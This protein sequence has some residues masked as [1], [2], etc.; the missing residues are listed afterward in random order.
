M[1]GTEKLE[2]LVLPTLFPRG[3]DDIL[4]VFVLDYLEAV[5]DFCNVT[6]IDLRLTGE[7]GGPESESRNGVRILRDSVTRRRLPGWLK[8]FAYLL[9]LYRGWRIAGELGRVDL[10]HAHGST[11]MGNLALLI[12]RRLKAPVVISEHGAPGPR[13]GHRAVALFL[14]RRALQAAD[15]VLFVS[16]GLRREFAGLG[17]EPR[18]SL[19]SY[20]PVDTGLFAPSRADRAPRGKNLLFVG[21]LVPFKGAMT[22]ARAFARICVNWPEWQLRIIGDGPQRKELDTFLS[23]HPDLAGRISILGQAPKEMIAAALREASVLV[24]PSER[25]TFGLVA[26]EAMASGVPV[27][28][29]SGTGPVEFVDDC[30]GRVVPAGDVRALADAM[31]YIMRHQDQFDPNRIRARIVERFSFAAFG[32]RMKEAYLD[33]L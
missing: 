10:I 28:V 32:A 3:P 2:L 8:P 27:I 24:F 20:N 4:G 9:W 30:S 19:V 33:L 6:V 12:R 5:R 31:E 15:L 1:S 22:S 13:L 18:R 23:E 26:A 17:I 7:V 11:L 25:E 29:G 16:E 21:R 14:T